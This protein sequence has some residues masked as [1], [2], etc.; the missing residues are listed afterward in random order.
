MMLLYCLNGMPNFGDRLNEVICN[1]LFGIDVNISSP[2]KCEACF[3]GS[4]LDDFLSDSSKESY[5]N[6]ENQP[7]KLWGA[8][9][10]DGI[11]RYC[12][13]P[14]GMPETFFRNIEP[15][16]I[17][18]RISADRV[19]KICNC[20]I[21]SEVVIG[22]P[23][24]LASC[25]IKGGVKKYKWGIIPHHIEIHGYGTRERSLSIGDEGLFPDGMKFYIPEYE[26]LHR[27]LK[28][29]VVID[30][31]ADPIQIINRISECQYIISAALHGLIV[32]DALHVP[33]IWLK[34]SDLLIGNEYKFNDYYSGYNRIEKRITM[35]EAIKW[36]ND[37]LTSEISNKP[38]DW[39]HVDWKKERLLSSFPFR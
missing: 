23:G 18:G 34:A 3:I 7:V 19:F 12:K 1:K 14:F 39:Y 4:L 9:F 16:A 33:S 29:S 27:L 32:A 31:E 24:V 38:N 36:D 17:R 25:L 8:G 6:E 28:E 15:Y 13:R 21:P 10:I 22:D 2:Y 35:K 37:G 20:Y 30:M 5:N 11:N 26:I